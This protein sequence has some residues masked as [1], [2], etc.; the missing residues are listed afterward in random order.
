M[1]NSKKHKPLKS[2]IINSDSPQTQLTMEK[3]LEGYIKHADVWVLNKEQDW[4]LAKIISYEVNYKEDVIKIFISRKVTDP[5][6]RKE[7]INKEIKPPGMGTWSAKKTTEENTITLTFKSKISAVCK[8]KVELPY[9][10]N[11]VILDGID[12]LTNLSYLNEP[13]VLHDLKIRYEKKQIYTYSGV[14]LVAL[15]PFCPIDIYGETTMHQYVGQKRLR[16]SPHLYAVAE[17]AY[18]GMSENQRSQSIIVYGE[19]G[20]GKTTSAKYIMRYF[21]QS[22]RGELGEEMSH[23]EKQILATNPVFEAFGNAKTTRNDNS[24]RFGK[25]L[26]ILF[27]FDQQTIVGANTRTFLL[28]RSRICNLP[29]T[30]RNY[31]I[32]YQLLAGASE[33]TAKECFLDQKSWLDFNYLSKGGCGTISGVDDVKEFYSTCEALEL[34]G[35][36]K[37]KQ[38]NIWRVLSALL[39]IGNVSFKADNN[40]LSIDVNDSSTSFNYAAKLLGLNEP[41]FRKCLLKKTIITQRERILTPLRK[42]QSNV[43]KDSIAK[44]LYSRLFDWMLDPLNN[45]LATEKTIDKFFVGILD[46]YGFEYF[47]TNSFEQLCINYANEKLQHHF[48]NHVFEL[49]QQEYA[50]ENLTN[51]EFIGFHDNRPCIELIEGRIGVLAILDEESRLEAADDKTFVEKLY[52]QY[53]QDDTTPGSVNRRVS[54][55]RSLPSSY[56]GKPRFSNTGFTIQHYAYSVTYEGDGFL[57][58]NKDTVSE[59]LM[60]MMK[61]SSSPFVCE[62]IDHGINTPDRDNSPTNVETKNISGKL[63]KQSPTLGAVFKRSLAQL[64]S[65]ITSTDMHYIRCIKTNT[66][67]KPWT[68]EQGLIVSQLR[69]CGVLETIKISKAGYPSRV[70]IGIFN[71]R[72][73]LLLP[74]ET[75]AKFPELK[76]NYSHHIQKD[77][78]DDEIKVERN[79]RSVE[80]SHTEDSGDDEKPT[81]YGYAHGLHVANQSKGFEE[82]TEE[83]RS[84]SKLILEACIKDQDLYQ[85]GLTKVFF[86]A[87]QWAYLE[88]MRVKLFNSSATLIQKNYR[89]VIERKR[90]LELKKSTLTIQEWWKVKSM[91]VKINKMQ[92]KTA[93]RTISRFWIGHLDKIKSEKTKLSDDQTILDQSGQENGEA[94]RPQRELG[95]TTRRTSSIYSLYGLPYHPGMI[96]KSSSR[97]MFW[98]EDAGLSLLHENPNLVSSDTK[99]FAIIQALKYQQQSGKELYNDIGLADYRMYVKARTRSGSADTNEDTLVFPVKDRSSL[100]DVSDK[101]LLNNNA[102]FK[103][104]GVFSR[105]RSYTLPLDSRGFFEAMSKAHIPGMIP[106][107]NEDTHKTN[108]NKYDGHGPENLEKT[109][110]VHNKFGKYTIAGGHHKEKYVPNMRRIRG[111]NFVKGTSKSSGKTFNTYEEDNVDKYQAH[112]QSKLKE[113]EHI[114]VI[115]AGGL[116]RVSLTRNRIVNGVIQPRAR[117]GSF[118][119]YTAPRDTDLGMY[120]R[121]GSE[122]GSMMESMSHDGISILYP[123]K[124][125]KISYQI[126]SKSHDIDKHVR[127]R[128]FDTEKSLK[129]MELVQAEALNRI[130]SRDVYTVMPTTAAMGL[131]KKESNKYRRATRFR[132]AESDFYNEKPRSGVYSSPQK[133]AIG[134][135]QREGVSSVSKISG[136]YGYPLKPNHDF[137]KTPGRSGHS[138]NI[139]GVSV[140]TVP[141]GISLGRHTAA[142]AEQR[143]KKHTKEQIVGQHGYRGIYEG[144]KTE[145]QKNMFLSSDNIVGDQFSIYSSMTYGTSILHLDGDKGLDSFGDI[146]GSKMKNVVGQNGEPLLNLNDSS[147]DLSLY[148]PYR[149]EKENLKRLASNGH[150]VSASM[151]RD[152]YKGL[153]NMNSTRTSGVAKQSE[154]SGFYVDD[155]IQRGEKV[156]GVKKRGNPVSKLKTKISKALFS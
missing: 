130:R 54:Q 154:Q 3:S 101:S 121:S 89:R 115:N 66:D 120:F 136:V 80:I 59:E 58:K 92:K 26:E 104:S 38:E 41:E 96:P 51:W 71:H 125:N 131:S 117:F 126:H 79:R 68:F 27:D 76:K 12:D 20:A 10:R 93:A 118:T 145:P 133:K 63:K 15:N 138:K 61:S 144:G 87:G 72:Y 14:V 82:V 116:D 148:D 86:R 140:N 88:N 30:E 142:R 16:N 109:E 35:I 122:T 129:N 123:G 18:N 146:G 155:E 25:Y 102:T 48:N 62:L 134:S 114:G 74:Y 150:K 46:I 77:D 147:F 50:N 60:E 53:I 28:E 124:T 42:T 152:E 47:D 22:R 90:F 70:N 24:S 6:E 44:F 40:G 103:T 73:F 100:P 33:Q 107:S 34:V 108:E 83:D 1:I 5:D 128:A 132:Q 31:H 141:I 111:D 143:E 8:K 9:L 137:S 36:N 43:L 39:H 23:V 153:Q 81:V 95:V 55:D 19:S 67:K 75:R 13:S 32:F 21:A 85:V 52:K 105:G 4:V 84:L 57:E 127:S 78:F 99:K 69:S 98:H 149:K 97:F 110:M 91:E 29:E 135:L 151:S 2:P 11:P 112:D 65:K 45:A 139:S 94:Y 56:F 7:L 119:S 106:F 17:D 64:I 156:K 49:E 37:K 113:N